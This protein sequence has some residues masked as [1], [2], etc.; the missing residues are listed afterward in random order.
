MRK[1]ALLSAALLLSALALNT[2]ATRWLSTP[3][4]TLA[5]SP[6]QDGNLTVT[7]PNTVVNR[8]ATLAADGAAGATTI[9]VSNPGG[10][11]GLDPAT[12]SVGDLL[13]IIQMQGAQI[14]TSDTPAYG[15]V[16]ALGNAGRY[17]FLTVGGVNGNVITIS[18]GGLRFS[19]TASGKVQVLRVPQY[20]TLTI[21]AGA[22]VTAP[23]WNGSIGGV[24]A[25]Q[26]MNTA[27][28][29][30]S[31]DASGLGFRGGQASDN[32]IGLGTVTFRTTDI[33][34]GGEKGEGIVGNGVV[35]DGI[36]GRFGRGAAA[37]AGGGGTAHNSGGGGG[38][39]GNNGNLYNG[40]GVMDGTVVGAAAWALDPA[41]AANGNA[42]TNSSG[43]GRGGYSYSD[44]ADDQNAL[45]TGP[46][47]AAWEGD[48][49]RAVG[50]NGGRPVSND[51]ANRLFMGGGGGAPH[52]N[53][54]DGGVGGNGGGL[55]LLLANVVNGSGSIRVNGMNGSDSIDEHRDGAGGAGA[56]GTAVVVAN[57]LSGISIQARGGNGG[58]HGMPIGRFTNEGHGPGGGGGGGHISVSGGSVSTDVSGGSHGVSLASTFTEFPVNGATRGATGSTSPVVGIPFSCATDLAITKTSGLSFIFP[59]AQVTYTI[60]ARNNGPNPV[61]GAPVVDIL[62]GVLSGATW[63]CSASAG[64]ACGAPSGVGNINTTVNLLVNGT[65]TFTLTA[66]LSASASGVLSNTATV[67]LPAGALD[68]VPGN[69]TATDTVPISTGVTVALR[70]NFRSNDICIGAGRF[71]TI[72]SVLTNQGPGIQRDN[73]GPE[74]TASIPAQLDVLPNSCTSSSGNCTIAGSTVSW[75][76]AI[77]T[78]NSVTITYQARIRN[79]VSSGT[80]FCLLSRAFYDSNG[81]GS[82]D[83]AT[84]TNTC[85]IAN[86][87]PSTP[88]SNVVG[89]GEPVIQGTGAP[90]DQRPGSVLIFPV[91]TSNAA[92]PT[93]SNTRISLTNTSTSS[94]ANVHLF[95]VD[96][97]SCSISDQYLCL[98]PGQTSTFTTVEF[99][100]GTS[101][102]L[103]AIATDRDGYPL[104]F[105]HL[106]G[107]AYV[108][109]VVGGTPFFG[110]YGAEAYAA[111]RDVEPNFSSNT[112][113][114]N[115]NGVDY[116]FSV[117]THA[118]SNIGSRLDGN[119]TWLVLAR[120]GG[121]LLTG[122]GSIGSIF[123]ILY[124]DQESAASF[125]FNAGCQFRGILS[126][127]FPRTAPRFDDKIPS[128]QS[129]W[130]RFSTQGNGMIGV[131]FRSNTSDAGFNG[132][133][134]LHKL[135]LTTDAFVMPVFPP[136]C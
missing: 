107:D 126:N 65:A 124:D 22:S 50:G 72:E 120:T 129:G 45:T 82:N 60:T 119:S 21:N 111:L 19:Y 27:T 134:V 13:L 35:Y 34:L 15:L 121:S 20:T 24:V 52:Q 64:S 86:C 26:A 133:H 112:A 79:T 105:N 32:G 109:T 110:N 48:F 130:M 68:P 67:A 88:G 94:A 116:D 56:G 85:T 75:N 84:S 37:N 30:G 99:D 115:F 89:P 31:I 74:Y 69:N 10:N 95:F 28:I 53:N 57:N 98:T 122:V 93:T 103:V 128:G 113:T 78:N 40:A 127:D 125:N 25:A 8:Y 46:G 49:R 76:G 61:V 29:N 5:G 131:A 83:T 100:P 102:F 97:T 17:E 42:L 12:L 66:T 73:P 135:T 44:P 96:G 47:N 16:T 63:T 51:P 6:D 4:L 132:V 59:G 106:I 80:R 104:N 114:I 70:T 23:A 92:A 1:F 14:D 101:G 91:Y 43:G 36:G 87:S 33:A 2:P 7:A 136:S 38:A 54:Q 3:S 71:I 58:T 55:V 62:P 117:R 18:C 9:T 90:N 41:F 77:G 81:D 108:K 39:N 11:F 118:V 123:G